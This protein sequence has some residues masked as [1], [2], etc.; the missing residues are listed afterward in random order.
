MTL[1]KRFFA[2]STFTST[3]FPPLRLK[4]DPIF[5]YIGNIEFSLEG[6]LNG[7]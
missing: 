1:P 4:V 5:K 3:D 7:P 2:D 6:I